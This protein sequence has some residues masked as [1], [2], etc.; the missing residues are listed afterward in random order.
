M[1][2]TNKLIIGNDSKSKIV[3]LFKENS[4]EIS[5]IEINDGYAVVW[6]D[7]EELID[8]DFIF[9]LNEKLKA[10]VFA[11]FIQAGKRIAGYCAVNKEGECVDEVIDEETFDKMVKEFATF[12]SCESENCN[13]GNC[14]E[15]EF[16]VVENKNVTKTEIEMENKMENVVVVENVN[17][18]LFAMF[19]NEELEEVGIKKPAVTKVREARGVLVGS[20]IKKNSEKPVS[21]ISI[22]AQ[23]LNE[24]E[25]KKDTKVLITRK[26]VDNVLLVTITAKDTSRFK[27]SG[28]GKNENYNSLYV[29]AGDILNTVVKGVKA[30]HQVKNGSLNIIVQLDQVA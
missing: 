30:I 29:K 20:Y 24:L 10:S 13:E 28:G 4:I 9:H 3:K 15:C 8:E 12:K 26:V 22:P 6:A 21:T 11:C 2:I 1:N 25:W 17:A 27:L 19:D 16:H 14:L 7:T 5:S 18:D 23:V